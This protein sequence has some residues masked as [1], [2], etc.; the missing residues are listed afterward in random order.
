MGVSKTLSFAL[1]RA[2]LPLPSLIGTICPPKISETELG[3]S[4]QQ[5]IGLA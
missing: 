3:Q 1:K 2:I 4:Q 5:E